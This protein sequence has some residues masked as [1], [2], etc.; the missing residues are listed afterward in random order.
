M[1]HF[2]GGQYADLV[3]L[4]TTGNRNRCRFVAVDIDRHGDAGDPAANWGYA[5]HLYNKLRGIGFCPLLVDSNGA[6]GYH[7]FVAFTSQVPAALA[8]VFVVWL[9]S[10]F[11]GHGLTAPPETF[12]KQSELRTAGRCGNFVRLPGRHHTR[13]HWSRVWDGGQWLEGGE[14]VELFLE[15]DGDSPDLIPH[16]IEPPKGGVKHIVADPRPLPPSC[17]VRLAR[18]I[19]AYAAKVP[20]LNEGQGRDDQ[21]FKLAAFL[22]RDL[23]QS[24]EVALPFLE[25]WDAGNSPPKGTNRLRKIIHNAR[26]RPAAGRVRAGW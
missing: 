12:P 13:E 2:E 26:V 21:A 24:D 11:A 17:P 20:N 23:G 8:W 7:L 18:R 9:V 6:G 22:V 10:D 16:D 14:A 19:R 4:H 1:R 25:E 5:R 3:G 15:L